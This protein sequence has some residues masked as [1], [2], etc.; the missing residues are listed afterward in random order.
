MTDRTDKPNRRAV[1]LASLGAPAAVAVAATGG[2]PAE[3]REIDEGGS[4][5]MRETEHTRAYYASAR[6]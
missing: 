5:L 2:E 4:P 1:L 6:F 3:A